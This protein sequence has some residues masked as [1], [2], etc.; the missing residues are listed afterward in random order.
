MNCSGAAV[1]KICR[2]FNF[3]P[4]DVLIIYDDVSL[5]LGQIRLRK[6]GSSGGQNGVQ[7]IIDKLGTQQI[8]RIRIGVGPENGQSFE[9]NLADY[10]L[11]NFYKDEELLLDE[12]LK[13]SCL[14]V[15]QILKSGF[16]QAMNCYN[17]KKISVI[18]SDDEIK[19][20]EN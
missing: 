9:E 13:Q 20:T 7:D 10:V 8:A 11:A 16:E 19:E 6:K 1:L 15:R 18:K 4:Q 12:V 3:A 14:A 2:K 5:P 17:G